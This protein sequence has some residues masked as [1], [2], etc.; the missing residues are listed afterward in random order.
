MFYDYNRYLISN[1]PILFGYIYY[2]IK[3]I[4]FRKQ[5]LKYFRFYVN[6][7]FNIKEFLWDK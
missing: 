1:Q 2:K 4:F 6:Y 5:T 7:K 3:N